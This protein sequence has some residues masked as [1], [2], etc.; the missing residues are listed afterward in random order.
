MDLP[1]ESCVYPFKCLNTFG[2][3]C[4]IILCLSLNKSQSV[5]AVAE[6]VRFVKRAVV[7]LWLTLDF[8]AC[9]SL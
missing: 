6:V 8:S 9:T 3:L 1:Q 7:V 4:S 5:R 2:N